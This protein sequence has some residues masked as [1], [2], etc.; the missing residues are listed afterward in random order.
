LCPP[1]VGNADGEGA[2]ERRPYVVGIRQENVIGFEVTM[3]DAQLVCGVQATR[4]LLKNFRNLRHG[5]RTPPREGLT[6]GFA[7]QILHG[8]VGHA[9]IGLAGF[10]N[11]DDIG[12][13]NAPRG[14]RFA[15]VEAAETVPILSGRRHVEA[16]GNRGHPAACGSGP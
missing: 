16:G 12:V 13:M 3:N 10:V 1:D 11:G 7:F 15:D 2:H 5:K 6:E 14:S 9:I 4:R 8:D